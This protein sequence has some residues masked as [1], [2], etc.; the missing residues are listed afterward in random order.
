[1]KQANREWVVFKN[2]CICLAACLLAAAGQS[3]CSRPP[4]PPTVMKAKDFL[5]RGISR[6]RHADLDGAIADFDKAI[7]MRP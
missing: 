5:Q 4:R 2:C 7:D 1:M 3:G 6:Y